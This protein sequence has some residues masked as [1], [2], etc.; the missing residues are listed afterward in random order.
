MALF[1]KSFRRTLDLFKDPRRNGRPAKLRNLRADIQEAQL[2]IATPSPVSIVSITSPLWPLVPEQ[3]SPVSHGDLATGLDP[4]EVQQPAI[5]TQLVPEEVP[6][7]VEVASDEGTCPTSADLPYHNLEAEDA[8]QQVPAE[9]ADDQDESPEGH[10]EYPTPTE[11][12]ADP[13]VPQTWEEQ[14]AIRDT[15]YAV[16]SGEDETDYTAGPPRV[17]CAW[18]G[19]QTNCGA[20][21][22]TLE[23]S[24][25]IRTAIQFQRDLCRIERASARGES[26]NMQFENELECQIARHEYRLLT[27]EGAYEVEDE[28]D[29]GDGEGDC[30]RALETSVVAIDGETAAEIRQIRH[31]LEKLHLLVKNTKAK[32]C[33]FATDVSFKLEMF[34]EVHAELDACLEE[35]FMHAALVE[36]EEIMEPEA[37]A[38]VLTVEGEYQRICRMAQSDASNDPIEITPLR[39]YDEN[40][41]PPSLSPADQA[42]AELKEVYWDA[43]RDLQH[44]QAL[45]DHRV[46][47]RAL[48]LQAREFAVA[49]GLPV[50]DESP[51]AFDLRWFVRIQELTRGVI[52]AEAAVAEARA[53]LLEA[54]GRLDERDQ[55]SGF[56]DH[57]SDGYR[58]SLEAAWVVDAQGDA[59]VVGWLDGVPDP[60]EMVP[61]EDDADSDVDVEGWEARSVDVEDS[62]S[63]V[64][65]GTARRKIDKWRQ[66]CGAIRAHP[67]LA[68]STASVLSYAKSNAPLIRD[69]IRTAAAT[70]AA[71]PSISSTLVAPLGEYD[72]KPGP[73]NHVPV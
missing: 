38:E 32:R 40:F 60:D 25:K 8:G 10:L 52:D 67:A 41:K 34:R 17:I 3:E 35:A 62:A 33:G 26:V 37:P 16:F 61:I 24:A 12:A 2:S 51:E 58:M 43:Q 6:A 59:K 72:G 15:E 71:K 64:A 65:E 21:L 18:D 9:A 1:A 55:E 30:T 27:L 5:D 28:S 53:A 19:V 70:E 68:F 29:S 11:E 50:E 22:L 20:L 45:F 44:A 57:A 73:A 36:P 4:D 49:Q 42:I 46:H 7:T 14:Q 54:G 23:L 13:A 63:F 66:T 47:T 56:A 69:T 48:E 31:E 39:R